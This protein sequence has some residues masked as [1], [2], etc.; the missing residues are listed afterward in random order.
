MTAATLL[1]LLY[2]PYLYALLDDFRAWLFRFGG[3]VRA[4]VAT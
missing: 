1:T 4:R 2:V 3:I